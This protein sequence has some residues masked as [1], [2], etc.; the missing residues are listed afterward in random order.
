MVDEALEHIATLGGAR[1]DLL[2][3]DHDPTTSAQQPVQA[4]QRDMDAVG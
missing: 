2:M 3:V 1:R 4:G